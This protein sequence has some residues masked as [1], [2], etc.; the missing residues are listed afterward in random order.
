MLHDLLDALPLQNCGW[1]HSHAAGG[2][3]STA[4]RGRPAVAARAPCPYAAGRPS[5]LQG[6]V[7]HMLDAERVRRVTG[8][9]ICLN[10]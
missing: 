1:W 8:Y 6:D 5:P 2:R 4:H 9:M 7:A 10:K 3:P